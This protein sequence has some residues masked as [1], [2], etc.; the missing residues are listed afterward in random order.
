M[1]SIRT[2]ERP[3]ATSSKFSRFSSNVMKTSISP[4]R[5]RP[6]SRLFVSAWNRQARQSLTWPNSSDRRTG[7]RDSEREPPTHADHDSQAARG[8]QNPSGRANRRGGIIGPLY[9]PAEPFAA[10]R[11]VPHKTMG[12]L[13]RIEEVTADGLVCT[14][15]LKG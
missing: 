4:W 8:P 13:W 9:A 12:N 7:V 6:R 11:N 5:S 2:Q 15:K 1:I 10:G 14:G 3:T